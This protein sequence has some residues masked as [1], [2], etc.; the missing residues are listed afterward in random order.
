MKTELKTVKYSESESFEGWSFLGWLKGN[1]KTIKEA[2]KIGVPFIF[3]MAVFQDNASLI[4]AVTV[5]GKLAIDSL[6]YYFSTVEVK[7]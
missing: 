6:E 2:V 4:I 1:W 5:L 7:G 3:G